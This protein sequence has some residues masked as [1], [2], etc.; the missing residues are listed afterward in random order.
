MKLIKLGKELGYT[1]YCTDNIKESDILT[2]G[3]GLYGW[4]YKSEFEDFLKNGFPESGIKYGQYGSGE[5]Y[6][7]KT[8]LITTSRNFKGGIIKDSIVF[9]Y[10]KSF[11]D[12]NKNNS[13]INALVIENRL[14]NLNE[15]LRNLEAKSTE[16]YRISPFDYNS[17]VDIELRK[18]INDISDLY[19]SLDRPRWYQYL[20]ID[21]YKNKYINSNLFLL[22][23]SC[24]KGKSLTIAKTLVEI[25][26]KIMN[27]VFLLTTKPSTLDQYANQKTS[28]GYL[29]SKDI[30]EKYHIV[31]LR[32]DINSDFDYDKIKKQAGSKKIIFISSKQFLDK[33][34]SSLISDTDKDLSKFNESFKNTFK[35]KISLVISDEGHWGANTEI[36]NKIHSS[37]D[38]D[39]DIVGEIKSIFSKDVKILYS[40][41][42]PSSLIFKY[43]LDKD[44]QF[45]LDNEIEEA[46]FNLL[47]DINENSY[48]KFLDIV[49]NNSDNR[50]IISTFMKKYLQTEFS[51]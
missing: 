33:Y 17:L 9:V 46:F 30:L 14:K 49:S 37:S 48:N 39:D 3:Q 8:P 50:E 25:H 38:D 19:P 6:E 13:L 35:S 41:A 7:D 29:Y 27:D 51:I 20:F 1:F 32:D 10:H 11:N 24:G 36:T 31:Y 28:T 47:D 34:L 45:Y 23:F 40:T 21:L 15:R 16:V 44:L 2:I 4:I 18:S 5:N 22:A 43:N 26:D 12:I 42:T